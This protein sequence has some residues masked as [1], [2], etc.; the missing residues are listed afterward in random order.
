MLTLSLYPPCFTLPHP[1]LTQTLSR[2]AMRPRDFSGQGNL[3]AEILSGARLPRWFARWALRPL[4]TAPS[5]CSCQA[6][7]GQP[8]HPHGGAG[9]GPLGWAPTILL[10]RA[11]RTPLSRLSWHP[12]APTSARVD[13]AWLEVLGPAVPARWSPAVESS[14]ARGQPCIRSDGSSSQPGS[15]GVAFSQGPLDQAPTSPPCPG[16]RS[17]LGIRASQSGCHS[18]Q[19]VKTEVFRTS[20]L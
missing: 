1:T 14:A 7:P 3:C 12:P 19:D 9:G 6:L 8:L 17:H 15:L 4:S 2:L 18:D 16:L 11:L 5:C 10:P 20:N 13:F